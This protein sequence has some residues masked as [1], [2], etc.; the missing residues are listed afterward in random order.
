[1]G[2]AP[3]TATE[4]PMASGTAPPSALIVLDFFDFLREGS[5]GSLDLGGLEDDAMALVCVDMVAVG[6]GCRQGGCTDNK[7]VR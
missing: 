5:L 3:S 1:M 2:V 6:C 4:L 7:E